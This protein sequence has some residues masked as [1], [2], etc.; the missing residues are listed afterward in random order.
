MYI[1]KI[2]RNEYT[3][4]GVKHEYWGYSIFIDTINIK[5]EVIR[6]REKETDTR[7]M[8]YI[9]C[10]LWAMERIVGYFNVNPLKSDV[11]NVYFTNQNIVQWFNTGVVNKIYRIAFDKLMGYIDCLPHDT[12]KI[13]Q[14]DRKWSFRNELVSANIKRK[15]YKKLIDILNTELEE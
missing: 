7:I 10:Y 2:D 12:V 5:T 15:R 3:E 13:C 14:A 11:V 9:R 1:V 4:N 8:G 6:A